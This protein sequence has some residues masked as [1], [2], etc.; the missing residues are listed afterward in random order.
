MTQNPQSFIVCPNLIIMRDQ[1]IPLLR[2]AY[3]APLFPGHWHGPTGKI[4]DGESQ[5]KPSSE[6]LLKKWGL[7]SILSLVRL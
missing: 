4:E 2:R 7:Q 3:W 6:K 5:N 1:K